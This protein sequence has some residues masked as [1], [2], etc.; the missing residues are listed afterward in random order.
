VRPPAGI[1]PQDTANQCNFRKCVVRGHGAQRPIK[2]GQ[3]VRKERALK[4]RPGVR[5][6]MEKFKYD[7]CG[8]YGKESCV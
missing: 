7:R 5:K 3:V 6:E 4:K 2:K 1:I 8:R